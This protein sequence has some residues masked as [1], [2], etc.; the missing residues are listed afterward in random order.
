VGGVDDAGVSARNSMR[1]PAAGVPVAMFK[2]CVVSVAIGPPATDH[3]ST[4]AIRF[5]H[6]ATH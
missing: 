3:Y 6:N 2:T 1:I 4:F 5:V